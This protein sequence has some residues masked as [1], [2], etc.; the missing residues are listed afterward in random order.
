MLSG[1]TAMGKFPREAV[2]MMARIVAEAEA[3][4]FHPLVPGHLQAEHLS[5]AETICE[6][7]AHAAKDLNIRAVAVF[8]ETAA[9]ARMLSKYR[10]AADIY[11]F[12]QFETVCNRM[13]LLWGVAPLRCSGGLSA[14]EMAEF[15]EEELVLR[16]VLSRRRCL[17]TGCRD[18]Q[19]HRRH[20]LY[21][22]DH[23]GRKFGARQQQK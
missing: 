6:S 7:M 10:P 8:T 1:E 20:Q 11:A 23:G 18:H 13:N 4:P 21:A 3:H 9:T 22:A 12:T 19:Q 15:A 16:K 2:E 14:A 5:I 17:R